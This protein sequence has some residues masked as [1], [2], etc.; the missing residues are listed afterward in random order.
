MKAKVQSYIKSINFGYIANV[1][2]SEG[3]EY[4]NC[5]G[6]FKDK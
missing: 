5:L 4:L 3:M 6:A 2:K 1:N